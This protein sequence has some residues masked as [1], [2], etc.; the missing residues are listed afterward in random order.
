MSIESRFPRLLIATDFAPTDTGG[1]AALVRQLL[2]GYPPENIFWWSYRMGPH[3]TEELVSDHIVAPLPMKLLPHKKA[4]RLKSWLLET[5]WAPLAARHLARVATRIR[6]DQVWALPYMWCIPAL[7]QSRLITTFHSH[8]SI[9]DYPDSRAH[10]RIVGS[11]RAEK[12]M[13][14]VESLYLAA[15]SRDVISRAMQEDLASRTGRQDAFVVHSG[16]DEWHLESVRQLKTDSGPSIRIA[17]AGSIIV[18]DVFGLFVQALELLRPRLPRPVKLEFYGGRGQHEQPWFNA[19]WMTDH[20]HL[21]EGA[22]HEAL[23]QCSWGFLPM[24]LTDEDPQYNRFSFPNK[25]G[26]Y[27]S[28]GLPLIVVAHRDSSAA[29]MIRRYP[30]GIFVDS[31][32]VQEMAALLQPAIADSNSRQRFHKEIVRCAETEFNMNRMRRQLWSAFGVGTSPP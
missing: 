6:P 5:C 7:A 12:M 17:Y 22:F 10:H 32:D 3:T 8:V 19:E 26:T 25:F 23:R 15:R 29:S 13:R 31:L 16:I 24:S 30:V 4:A 27:L 1:G 28:A 11:R 2:K 18:P 9:W 21:E 14:T 20:P